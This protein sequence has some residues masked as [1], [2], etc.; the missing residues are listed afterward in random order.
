MVLRPILDAFLDGFPTV[1]ARLLLLD[2]PV[3]PIHEGIDFAPRIAHLA[4]SSMVAT[5]IGEVRRLVV[6][7]PRYLK[8]HPR[9]AEP[10]R[11]DQASDRHPGPSWAILD[12]SALAG[13]L[14]PAHAPVRAPA[15]DQHH[16]WRGRLGRRRARGRGG[17]ILSGRRASPSRRARSGPGGDDPP[18]IPVHS[19][20]PQGRLSV[21]KLRALH[22]F[23]GAPAPNPLRASGKRC[24]HFRA[25]RS[26]VRKQCRSLA[27]VGAFTAVV[28]KQST[29]AKRLT[30]T[31]GAPTMARSWR[32]RPKF[33]WLS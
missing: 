26:I 1:S 11:P 19:I 9:I 15:G 30:P 4:D 5:R 14:R 10:G 17:F 23:C 24:R 29:V 16:S 20:S 25:S 6:A 18:P 31:K 8:Q 32:P 21:P 22:G 28:M 2:R 13:L 27:S 12:L 33:S 7:A 3:N